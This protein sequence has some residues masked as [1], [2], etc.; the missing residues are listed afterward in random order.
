MSAIAL[1]EQEPTMKAYHEIFGLSLK[2]RA[3]R[4]VKYLVMLESLHRHWVTLLNSLTVA[5]L[6]RTFRHREI[7]VITLAQNLCLYAWQGRHHAAHTK[8]RRERMG[9][10]K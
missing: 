4:R 2:T 5:D 7:G 1:T 6:A 9:W 8:S 10:D 3:L